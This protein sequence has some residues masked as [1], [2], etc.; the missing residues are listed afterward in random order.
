MFPVCSLAG[1][2][3]SLHSSAKNS[4]GDLLVPPQKYINAFSL[5]ENCVDQLLPSK[6]AKILGFDGRRREWHS[7]DYPKMMLPHSSRMNQLNTTFI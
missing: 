4:G 6:K 1:I 2:P 3:S 5:A 7:R